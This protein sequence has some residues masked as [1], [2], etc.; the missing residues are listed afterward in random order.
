MDERTGEVINV[1]GVTRFDL[2][3]K[4]I[5]GDFDAGVPAEQVN[6][7]KLV[8]GSPRSPFATEVCPFRSGA[9]ARARIPYSN[10]HGR[11]IMG[12]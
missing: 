8:Y 3:V 11:F 2:A 6:G 9:G 7:V 1:M 12:V 4:A 5:R 10:R